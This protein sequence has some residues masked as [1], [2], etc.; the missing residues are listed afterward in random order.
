LVP[1]ITTEV[2]LPPE[3]GEKEI[4]VGTDADAEFVVVVDVELE[5][6]VDLKLK[7]A[8]ELPVP[9]GVEMLITPLD[10]FPTMAIIPVG[11]TTVKP[12]AAVPPKLT[13]VA[14][15]RL[16]PVITTD[17]PLPPEAGKKEVI[18]GAEADAAVEFDV[19]VKVKLWLELAEPFGVMT[20]I[21]P[22][23]PLPMAAVI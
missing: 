17:V 4:I 16:V 20:V 5:V 21:T 1:V 9:F 13:A 8:V 7:L 10:P 2:P 3:S 6:G 22:L 19:D 18:V 12:W 11:E 23:E 15:I 14:P